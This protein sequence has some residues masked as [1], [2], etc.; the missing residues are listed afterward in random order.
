MPQ[1]S[2]RVIQIQSHKTSVRL[3]PCEWKAI[4]TICQK[5]KIE[6]KQLF[7]L[8]NTNKDEKLG[9]TTAVRLF[10]IIYYKNS[11]LYANSSLN[12]NFQNS[13]FDAIDGISK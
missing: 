1:L 11:V 6:R 3:N 4:N 12:G 8:I 2:S 9:L 10:A 13:I 7:E 5:E